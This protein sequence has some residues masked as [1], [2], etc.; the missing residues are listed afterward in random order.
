MYA[1]VLG[2]QVVQMWNL[3]SIWSFMSSGCM[4]AHIR[5]EQEPGTQGILPPSY[6]R[7]FS[8]F[9]PLLIFYLFINHELKNIA[10]MLNILENKSIYL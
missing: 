3:P 7:E 9:I 2:V 1:A 10:K 8:P 5:S 4:S 6:K